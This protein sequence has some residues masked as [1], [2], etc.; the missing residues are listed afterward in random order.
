MKCKK[1]YKMGGAMN[2]DE[3]AQEDKVTKLLRAL[4]QQGTLM[5]RPTEKQKAKAEEVKKLREY[6]RMAADR[7][8]ER[9]PGKLAAIY[10]NKGR[11][12]RVEGL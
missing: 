10:T 6:M 2:G 7:R 9:G 1:N 12:I 5:Y 4:S 11:D 8:L 3:P